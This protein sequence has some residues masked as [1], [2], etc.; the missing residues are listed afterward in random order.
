MST[1]ADSITVGHF[2]MPP[3][4]SEYWETFPSLSKL[5]YKTTPQRLILDND[6]CSGQYLIDLRFSIKAVIHGNNSDPLGLCCNL[7]HHAAECSAEEG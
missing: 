3:P 7:A 1:A 5:D 2:S 4:P 6:T